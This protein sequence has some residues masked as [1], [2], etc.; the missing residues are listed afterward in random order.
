VIASLNIGQGYQ[1]GSTLQV[2][3]GVTVQLSSGTANNG[4][5]F[6]TRV[7]ANPD[8]AGL[9]TA[10]GINTFFTGNNAN[11]IAVQPNLV[12]NP[13]QLAASRTGQPGDGSNLQR[14]AA[15]A[16]QPLLANGTQT[17]SQFYGSMVGDAGTQVKQLSDQQ[18]AQQ[19][20]GQ[21]IEAQQQAVSGVDPNEEL[22]RELEAQ[23]AFEMA[24]RYI[25][26]VNT[27]LDSLFR[28]VDATLAGTG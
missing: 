23:R 17:F 10:L 26:T 7:V 21:R 25:S 27:T 1:P 22:V 14:M 18:S 24:S 3:N 12:N 8:T 5:S 16:D 20:I 2:G 28:I 9:L 11:N 15:L 4:D 6:T 19:L 13:A